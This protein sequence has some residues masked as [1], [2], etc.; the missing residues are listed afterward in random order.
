MYITFILIINKISKNSKPIRRSAKQFNLLYD[1][2]IK[3]LYF[4]DLKVVN[5]SFKLKIS[6]LSK[7]FMVIRRKTK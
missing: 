5:V 3:Q 7:Y 1:F 4:L 6:V 2:I